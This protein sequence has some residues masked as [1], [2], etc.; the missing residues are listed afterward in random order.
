MSRLPSTLL[1]LA[2]AAAFAAPAWAQQISTSHGVRTLARTDGFRSEQQYAQ[3][4]RAAEEAIIELLQDVDA[5]EKARGSATGNAAAIQQQVKKVDADMASAK[6]AFDLRDQQYRT[7]L[8][9]FEQRQSQLNADIENQRQQAAQ[10]EAQPSA[11]RDINEVQ[12]LNNWAAQLGTTRTQIEA[13]RT[14]LLADHDSIEA[15]RARL[16]Q[17]RSDALTRLNGSRDSTLGGFNQATQQRAA[18][19]KNLGI[20]VTYLRQVR[21]AQAKLAKMP[22]AH[23][24]PLETAM[25]K[26]SAYE[27]GAPVH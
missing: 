22:L 24:E 27:N 14:R 8:A 9:A 1:A 5:A 20:A 3:A 15:E 18:A 25:K 16:A 13:D 12:R 6:A 10:L 19:Y 11:Q 17:Q 21:E 23:S 4:G 7:D 2:L 26:L